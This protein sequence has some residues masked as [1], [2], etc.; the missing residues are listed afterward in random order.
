MAKRIY[1]QQAGFMPP[2]ASNPAAI[3]TKKYAL[4]KKVYTNYGLKQI[5]HEQKIWLLVPLFL[6]IVNAIISVTNVY[7]NIWI[8]FFIIL[9]TGLYGLF[10]VIQ[11][12]GVTQLEQYKPLFQRYA[13][14]IDSRQILMKTSKEEGG[15]MK[16]DMI[17]SAEKTSEAY[18][19]V[20]SKGQFLYLPFDIFN[21]EHDLK[22]MER[23]LVQKNLLNA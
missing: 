1:Q 16:W 5:W 21:S 3:K 6:I 10:W 19:L 9:C 12:T 2:V 8:Y 17:K 13:Y 18:I 14:E 11:F 15:I 20:I 22:L 4:D 23:I 7:P